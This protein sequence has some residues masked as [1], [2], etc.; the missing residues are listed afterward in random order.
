MRRLTVH[1][2]LFWIYDEIM[3]WLSFLFRRKDPAL[4]GNVIDLVEERKERP[5]DY[6]QYVLT[7]YYGIY[8]HNRSV[9]IGN[10]D[11]R[12][13]HN[14][15][16]YYAGNIGY[17]IDPAYRGHHYAYEACRLMLE[18]AEKNQMDYI[19]ITCSPGNVASRKTIEKLGA[20]Y[21]ETAD[22][23]CD[24]WLYQRGETVK[25]IYQ[26]SCGSEAS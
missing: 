21:L 8:L 2:F 16:L 14:V 1:V 7:F 17:H 26:Y 6:N 18:E 15:E 19:L 20:T 13:G 9:R 23:P 11:L 25:R 24:H 3:R 10:C 12:I 5:A 4:T 22:V